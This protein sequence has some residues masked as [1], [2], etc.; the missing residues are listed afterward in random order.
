MS[1]QTLSLSA[2][3]PRR[4]LCNSEKETFIWMHT[5]IN[6]DGGAIGSSCLK[7]WYLVEVEMLFLALY[8][9]LKTWICLSIGIWD[10]ENSVSWIS[11]HVQNL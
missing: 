11:L 4:Q 9:Q 6:K 3:T 1:P 8:T 2:A 7:D 5:P 10:K